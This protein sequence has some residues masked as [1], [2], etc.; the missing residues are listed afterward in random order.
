[1]E[2]LVFIREHLNNWYSLKSY[3]LANT[4]ADVPLQVRIVENLK[5]KLVHTRLIISPHFAVGLL[6]V[7]S[8]MVSKIGLKNK[9]LSASFVIILTT[10]Y[11]S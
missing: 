8:Q 6:S 11:V 3:Y 9:R 1:M 5:K 2:K 10:I 7:K 4:M